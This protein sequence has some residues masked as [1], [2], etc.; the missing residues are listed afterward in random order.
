MEMQP[1]PHT[2]PLLSKPFARDELR[3]KGVLRVSSSHGDLMSMA[4]R[5][6]YTRSRSW[7]TDAD[8]LNEADEETEEWGQRMGGRSKRD[9]Y[10][11]NLRTREKTAVEAAM[12]GRYVSE[13][14]FFIKCYAEGR[15]NVSN[16]PDPPPRR[17][18]FVHLA[19]PV[20]SDERVRMKVR[21]RGSAR[22]GWGD[23]DGYR[24]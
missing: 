3:N 2:H 8:E 10:A 19:A 23:A 16:P 1:S 6:R 11:R 24:R 12:D 14:G 5:H 21:S 4:G 7:R 17:P 15:F 9:S 18:E 20:P 13:W 22:R